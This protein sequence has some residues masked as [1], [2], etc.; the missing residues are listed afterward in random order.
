MNRPTG[1]I[2]DLAC[3]PGTPRYSTPRALKARDELLAPASFTFARETWETL[4]AWRRA[5]GLPNTS[6]ALRHALETLQRTVL[7]RP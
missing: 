4:L 3:R 6:A 7:D 2:T 5:H 1:H